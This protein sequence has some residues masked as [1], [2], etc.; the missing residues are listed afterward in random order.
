MSR[1]ILA[2]SIMAVVILILASFSSGVSARIVK[3][4]DTT[5]DN[6][7]DILLNR[8]QKSDR[9]KDKN[10]VMNKLQNIRDIVRDGDVDFENLARIIIALFF[11]TLEV[12]LLVYITGLFL[13]DLRF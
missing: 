10:A 6:Y 2:G 11:I 4:D 1:K 5:F 8:V 7:L 13:S 12:I 3:L 9:I